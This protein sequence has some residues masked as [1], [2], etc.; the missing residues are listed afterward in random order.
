[1]F[2]LVWFGLF[3][4][5]AVEAEAI[6]PLVAN[7]PLMS[8]LY[9]VA[10]RQGVSNLIGAAELAIAALVAVRPLAPLASAAGSLAAAGVFLTTLSFLVTTPGV[11]AVVDGLPVPVGA[12]GFLVKDLFLFG[13]ALWST[14]EAW[15][16]ARS[17]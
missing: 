3:K 16:A 8:W 9:V 7:S 1:V 4:F 2:F 11:W 14:G 6:E 15:R 12:G 5:T 10:S 13:A 17:R